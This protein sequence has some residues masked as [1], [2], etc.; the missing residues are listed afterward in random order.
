MEIINNS[1]FI[2]DMTSDVIIQYRLDDA[3]NVIDRPAHPCNTFFYSAT[4]AVEGLGYGPN[5]HIWIAGYGSA[6][7]YEIGGGALQL[8]F[9]GIP[10]QCVLPGDPFELFDLDDYVTGAP[11]FSW[12]WEG[13]VDLSVSVN[14]ENV[15][16]ITYPPGWIGQETITFTVEDALGTLASDDAT[17]TVSAAPV[18]GDIP[19]QT[20]PFDLIYL[21]DYLYDALPEM[22]TWTASGMSCLLVEINAATHVAAVTNPGGCTDPEEITFTATVVPCGE[23]MSDEDAAIFSPEFS[24]VAEESPPAFGL[25]PAAPNPS[26]APIQIRYSIPARVDLSGVTLVVH[27]VSGRLVR[28]LI[29]AGETGVTRTITWDG[30]DEQGTPLPSGTYFFKLRWDGKQAT[31]RVMLLR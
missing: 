7:L 22:V 25:G 30:N 3:G 9:E 10:D 17:F 5:N 21:D 14:P 8:A 23:M 1:L 2:S 4:P 15:V 27:D 24:G 28:T 26:E 13:N 18:V 6:V 31:Q 16:T 12:S 20:E 11:P 29:T 19:D